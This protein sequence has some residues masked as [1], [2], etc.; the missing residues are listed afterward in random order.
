MADQNNDNSATGGPDKNN[1]NNNNNDTY[2]FGEGF[3]VYNP[4]DD[5]FDDWP[6]PEKNLYSTEELFGRRDA[7]YEQQMLQKKLKAAGRGVSGLNCHSFLVVF[8]KDLASLVGKIV[9][10]EG[11]NFEQGKDKLI[12]VICDQVHPTISIPVD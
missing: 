6:D 12:Q 10:R 3:Q 2:I 11:N 1:N 4:V 8:A 9:W 5:N 7:V